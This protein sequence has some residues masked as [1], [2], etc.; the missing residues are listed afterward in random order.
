MTSF[1]QDL[2]DRSL[3][4]QRP[5]FDELLTQ[6]DSWMSVYLHLLCLSSRVAR[7]FSMLLLPFA[8]L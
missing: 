8:I 4:R 3:I 2:R 1:Y 7:Y 6:L 5:D